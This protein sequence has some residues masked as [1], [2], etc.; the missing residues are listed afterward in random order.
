M[1][2]I[3]D[4]GYGNIFSISSAFKKIGYECIITSE[5]EEIIN[6]SILVLPGVGSFKQAMDALEKKKL[7]NIIFNQVNEGKNIIGICLG[8]QMLFQYSSEFGIHDGLGLIKGKVVS[9]EKFSEGN[10]RVPNVGWRPLI[11]NKKN[12]ILNKKY[13]GEMVYFVHSF[14]PSV[15]IE[16]QIS[17]FIKYDKSIIH[18]SIHNK[19]IVGYQFHPEKSGN[20]GLNILDSTIKYFKKNKS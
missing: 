11:I 8:Y 7:K 6:S 2:T 13:D 3:V 4:Y 10:A 20:V 15:E 12:N 9:L 18:A 14:V 16:N 19:N 17:S 1:I 5:K